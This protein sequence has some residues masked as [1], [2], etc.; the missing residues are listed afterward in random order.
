MNIKNTKNH[1]SFAAQINQEY[2]W[3]LK[4][5][6]IESIFYVHVDM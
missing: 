1:L 6:Q 3:S 4:G 2:K 5:L